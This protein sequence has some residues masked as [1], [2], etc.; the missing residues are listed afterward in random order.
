MY[1]LVINVKNKQS[2][3][4]TSDVLAGFN[5][6]AD[7]GTEDTF[8]SENLFIWFCMYILYNVNKL[9]EKWKISI[10]KGEREG[11]RERERRR[12]RVVQ[13]QF[14]FCL[15]IRSFIGTITSS[16]PVFCFLTR[17]CFVVSFQNNKSLTNSLF[18]R[19]WFYKL[20]YSYFYKWFGN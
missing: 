15:L 1:I 11:G 17:T 6:T 5:V 13:S 8:D 9:D 16:I 3:I 2:Q 7:S 12:E 4:L 18:C 19:F 14:C 20:I 10:S